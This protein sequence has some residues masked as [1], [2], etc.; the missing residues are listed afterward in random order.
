VEVAERGPEL[1]VPERAHGVEPCGAEHLPDAD[2][3]EEAPGGADGVPDDVVAATV[4]DGA[5]GIGDVAAGE[6]QVLVAE[7][8]LARAGEVTTTPSLEPMQMEKLRPPPRRAAWPPRIPLRLGGSVERRHG[9][10]AGGG[11]HLRKF[12]AADHL[13]CA[14]VAAGV[15]TW[16]DPSAARESRGR[17]VVTGRRKEGG[18]VR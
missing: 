12:I 1:A 11:T 5:R 8:L 9:Q 17:G 14:V 16:I 18:Y 6:E 7:H 2:P 10:V 4:G 3:A 13:R 15:G